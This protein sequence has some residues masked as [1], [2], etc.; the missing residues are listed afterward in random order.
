MI[1]TMVVAAPQTQPR[2]AADATDAPGR[3][4]WL[5]AL[6]IGLFALVLRLLH[7]QQIRANDP[8]FDRPSVDPR[9]YHEWA[10]RIAGGDWLGDEPFFMAPLYAYFLGSL[11][12]LFGPDFLTPRIVHA[13]LGA[14][15]CV[16][17][18]RLAR[19]LFDHRVALLAGA[20]TAAYSMLIFYEGSLLVEN[21]LVPLTL[22]VVLA[23]LRALS[24]PSAGRWA[25]AGAGV[26]LTA[27]ARPNVLLFAPLLL[28]WMFGALR[29]RVALSRRFALAGVFAA[30]VALLVLPVT[31]RNL[32]VTGDATLIATSGGSNFYSG[33]NP[34]A[35]GAYLVPRPFPR[36]A[37]DDAREQEALYQQ[38]AEQALGRSLRPSEASAYW[39]GQGLAYI[40]EN[41]VAWLRLEAR[42]LALFLN[43]TEIWNNRS[44]ELSR[45]FSWV[46]RLPLLSFGAV[47]PLALLG[48]A[49]TARDWRRLFPLYAMIAV[50]LASALLFF[51]LSRYRVPVVPVL[52]VFAACGVMHGVDAARAQRF[53]DLSLALAVLALFAVAT[54]VPL[55]RPNLGMA[56]Y[57]LGNRYKDRGEWGLAIAQYEQAL[58]RDAS[59]LPLNNNLALVYEESGRHRPEAILAWERVLRIA[60]KQ[61]YSVFAERAR[62]HL[63]DLGAVREPPTDPGVGADR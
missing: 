41:P 28:L 50:Y 23:A 36:L 37:A 46:L 42:K 39:V 35:N 59:Y 25:L 43:A 52:I 33:N 30:G 9:V 60:T 49:A 27:V 63:R 48:L 44:I 7:L 47:A 54:H 2:T 21:L 16:L 8:F 14:L 34:D 11:Y 6:G 40:R 4:E 15:T 29:E 3:C 10:L 32:V 1:R 19:E 18:W 5:A 62:R 51:V 38:Y 12:W 45:P 31:V 53:R 56:Y 26:G 13:V 57:N 24:A 58:E 17:V 55:I 22:L 61:N 20:L